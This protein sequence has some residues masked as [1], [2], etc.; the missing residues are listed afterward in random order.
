MINSEELSFCSGGHLLRLSYF[1]SKNHGE[2]EFF[3][4]RTSLIL[5]ANGRGKLLYEVVTEVTAQHLTE[6]LSTY[7]Q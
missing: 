5:F 1:P 2:F 3:M 4:I 6:I 7:Q